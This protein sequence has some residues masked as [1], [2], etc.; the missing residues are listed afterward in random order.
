MY[1]INVNTEKLT[2]NVMD[3]ALGSAEEEFPEPRKSRPK[4]EESAAE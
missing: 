1:V 2:E 4:L 3:D